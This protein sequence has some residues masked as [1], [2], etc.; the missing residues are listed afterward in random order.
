MSEP[1][2]HNFN[3]MLTMTDRKE[4]QF[5]AELLHVTMGAFTRSALRAAIA[6]HLYQAPTCASG[7]PCYVPHMHP[8]RPEPRKD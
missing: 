4:L 8:P 1:A 3:V 6:H 7:Q 2:S 5:A